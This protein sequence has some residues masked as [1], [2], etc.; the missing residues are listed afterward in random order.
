MEE[1]QHEE[2]CRELPLFPLPRTVFLPGSTLP[3]HVFE[4][5]YRA[6]VNHCLQGD[7]LMGVATLR[8]GF[9]ESY[10]GSP[11]LFPE[12]GVGQIVGHQPF[13]D[14][15][16]NI[17]LRFVTRV[18]IAREL[19]TSE[20]F[21]IVEGLVLP[22]DPAGLEPALA[23]LR[24]LVLQVG[25][26]NPDAGEEA[27]GLVGLPGMELPDALAPRLLESIDEQRAYL[28][29]PR[30]VDRV[31]MVQDHLAR[32]LLHGQTVGDA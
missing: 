11:E 28:G 32:F 13:P 30:L 2:L 31:A 10:D 25:T 20:P 6:L 1:F 8:P 12:V 15:R 29:A 3:L 5:R 21:R 27:R 24:V 14:G 23:A 26:I 4:E 7:R 18:T 17:V 16:S 9:E 19:P 22:A